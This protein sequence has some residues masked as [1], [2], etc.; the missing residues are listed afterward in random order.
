[1]LD[2]LLNSVAA[3]VDSAV[4][5]ALVRSH[6]RMP[7]PL[8][9]TEVMGPEERLERLEA[10]AEAYADPR[11]LSHPDTFFPPVPAERAERRP[12]GRINGSGRVEDW[13]WG[14]GHACIT[15]TIADN[16]SGCA[17]NRTAAARVF[18]HEDRPRPT[19]VL[20]HGYLGGAWAFE[21][22]VWP[23]HWLFRIG[24]DVALVALPFHGVRA[25]AG[26]RGAPLFPGT[27]PRYMVEGFRQAVVDTR[28]LFSLLEERGAPALGVMG[29]SLGGYTAS[30]VSTVDS[31]VGFC[32][33]FIPLA[34]LPDVARLQGR[35]NG[36]AVQVAAQEVGL[37]RVL[38][39]VSPLARPPRV[40][41]ERVRVV[42]AEGDRI[43]PIAHARAL[44]E[45]FHCELHTFVGGHLLQ[46]GRAAPWR[47][48]GRM[49]GGLGLLEPRP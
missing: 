47:E 2:G 44:A 8:S 16:W 43:T 7:G 39:P 11:F 30:L 35:F 25:E 22:R 42:A 28:A 33:P 17:A 9:A 19:A 3:Q 18:L 45:H 46:F 29:M 36:T 48:V 13:T 26:H 38:T 23:V 32:V 12:V 24:L 37:R 34:D 21:T 6:R 41:P 15:P 14:S 1:M 4:R 40:A 10:F 20:V 49:L 31:R 5:H 27:D